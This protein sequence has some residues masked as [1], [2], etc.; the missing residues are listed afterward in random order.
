MRNWFRMRLGFTFL[1]V[2]VIIDQT[3]RTV[4]MSLMVVVMVLSAT[5]LTVSLVLPM[6]V[7]MGV[8]RASAALMNAIGDVLQNT[9]FVLKMDGP[10]VARGRREGRR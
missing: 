6:A 5:T 10:L 2:S 4:M 1:T 8:S 7:G 9:S 3:F